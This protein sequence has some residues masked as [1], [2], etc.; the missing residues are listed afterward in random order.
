[1]TLS[2]GYVTAF[3]D[4]ARCDTSEDVPMTPL[5]GGGWDERYVN[6]RLTAS[7]WLATKVRHLCEMCAE[8]EPTPQGPNE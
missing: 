8:L 7:G 3:C 1:M 6:A 5:A 4:G 2:D